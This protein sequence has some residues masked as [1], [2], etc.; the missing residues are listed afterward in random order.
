MQRYMF[1]KFVGFL[2]CSRI[3]LCFHWLSSPIRSGAM[4]D[5]NFCAKILAR[6]GLKGF[7][8]WLARHSH[9]T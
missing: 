1:V 8:P 6:A 4:A 9:L 5:H 7:T 2:A 3:Q